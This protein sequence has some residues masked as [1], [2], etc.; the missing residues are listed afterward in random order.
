[1]KPDPQLQKLLSDIDTSK[2]K[3][4]LLTNAYV[5][6]ATRVVKLLGVDKY[7]EGLTYCDY[8]AGK[9]L[10]KPHKDMFMKAMKA[11]GVESFQNCYFV[12][13]LSYFST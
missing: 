11:A 5:S 4:W 13:E 7:F 10:A 12:G 9:L 3:L 6:H 2:V 8:S 1:L